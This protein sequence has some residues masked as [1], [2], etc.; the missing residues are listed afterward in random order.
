MDVEVA[1]REDLIERLAVEVYGAELLVLLVVDVGVCEA[2]WSNGY[3]LEMISPFD[4]S[5]RSFVRLTPWM[6][7]ISPH[8]SVFCS[9]P[10]ID[11]YLNKL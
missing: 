8:F 9:S 7:T 1:V 5:C 6:R 2:E 4:Y 11:I 10:G 3:P